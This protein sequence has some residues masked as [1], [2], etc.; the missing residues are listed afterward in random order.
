MNISSFLLE[1]RFEGSKVLLVESACNYSRHECKLVRLMTRHPS[2]H[3][4]FHYSLY[5]SISD[6]VKCS[7]LLQLLLLISKLLVKLC[8]LLEMSEVTSCDQLDTLSSQE[9]KF[10]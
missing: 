2:I 1:S 10:L 6:F 8:D 9:S 3:D 4:D 7:Q 5:L